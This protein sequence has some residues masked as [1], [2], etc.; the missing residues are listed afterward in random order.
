V[1]KELARKGA[2]PEE[3]SKCTGAGTRCGTCVSTI[4]AIVH[5]VQGTPES[6][7]RL[8]VLHNPAVTA[9]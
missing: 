4:Q 6:R 7:R 5:E 1:I 8:E 2:C 3:V 9:A